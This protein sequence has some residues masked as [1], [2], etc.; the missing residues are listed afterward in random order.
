MLDSLHSDFIFVLVHFEYYQLQLKP[1]PR[2]PHVLLYKDIKSATL[3]PGSVAVKQA[4][5]HVFSHSFP[6]Q[7]DAPCDTD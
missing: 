6:P 7:T 3:H 2:I 4:M 1:P 5:V